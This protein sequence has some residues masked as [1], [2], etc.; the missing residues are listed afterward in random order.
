MS[1]QSVRDLQRLVDPAAPL[2]FASRRY[3]GVDRSKLTLLVTCVDCVQHRLALLTLT[4]EDGA[5]VARS[6]WRAARAVAVAA[7]DRRLVDLQRFC[8]P[9][10]PDAV[11]QRLGNEL[12]AATLSVL[13]VA[14]RVGYLGEPELV[15]RGDMSGQACDLLPSLS[16]CAMR[17]LT[18]GI[19]YVTRNAI[20]L[21][22]AY[23]P[24]CVASPTLK[25]SHTVAE[26]RTASAGASSAAGRACELSERQARRYVNA[27]RPTRHRRPTASSGSSS[28]KS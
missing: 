23:P 7:A 4:R 1:Q 20:R 22:G 27:A 18:R 14:L 25:R 21:G 10:D 24:R 16:R 6:R 28:A 17:T 2:R 13:D 12:I 15:F 26:R 5:A 9:A 3:A 19:L 11:R 8:D